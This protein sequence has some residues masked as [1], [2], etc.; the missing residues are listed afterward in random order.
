MLRLHNTYL[1]QC[2]YAANAYERLTYKLC[3]VMQKQAPF[4]RDL[5]ELQNLPPIAAQM[6]EKLAWL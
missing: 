3:D 6:M 4:A 5:Y 2:C 1:V